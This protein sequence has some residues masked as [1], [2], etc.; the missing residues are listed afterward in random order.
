MPRSKT[1]TRTADPC[2]VTMTQ[3]QVDAF[4]TARRQRKA[5][6]L[7][8]AERLTANRAARGPRPIDILAAL[9][10]G[11]SHLFPAPKYRATTQVSSLLRSAWLKTGAKFTSSLA[12]DILT[13][14]T[15]AGVRVT[16]VS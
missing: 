6:R 13:G 16:R 7:A 1:Y 12:R 4:Y 2:G 10:V 14:E 11:A 8:R 5:E 9:A 3:D 15:V